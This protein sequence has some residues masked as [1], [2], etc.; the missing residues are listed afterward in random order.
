MTITALESPSS[1][2][3]AGFP[4][5]EVAKPRCFSAGTTVNVP[6]NAGFG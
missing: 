3:I 1:C 5:E 2:A 6:G 4:A